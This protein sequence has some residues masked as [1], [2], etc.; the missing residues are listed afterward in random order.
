MLGGRCASVERPTGLAARLPHPSTVEGTVPV[1]VP[2]QPEPPRAANGD[3]G[4]EQDAVLRRLWER[5][6]LHD[7]GVLTEE[8][9][10]AA[11]KALLNRL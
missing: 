4:S 8:E 6:E 5:G 2:A 7:T 10:G 9:V 3:A 1:P 11:K